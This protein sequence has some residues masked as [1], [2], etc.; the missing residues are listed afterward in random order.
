VSKKSAG[1]KKRTVA[2][3]LPEV[4]TRTVELEDYDPFDVTF[5][6]PTKRSQVAVLRE[7]SPEDRRRVE[8][9]EEK[10]VAAGGE[11]AEGAEG[12]TVQQVE[13]SEEEAFAFDDWL[14][15]IAQ[16]H[17]QGWTLEPPCTPE[18]VAAISDHRLVGR[19]AMTMLQA[20][21]DRK[22]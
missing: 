4:V 6:L 16:E 11:T 10:A 15:R 2:F 17:L 18:N 7:L 12:T 8:A 19:I 1:T 21:A 20:A 13:L 3:D 5:R 14:L 9:A 22:N